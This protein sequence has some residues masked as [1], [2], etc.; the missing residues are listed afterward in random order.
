MG[1]KASA[2]LRVVACVVGCDWLSSLE[3]GG[4]KHLRRHWLRSLRRRPKLIAY[5]SLYDLSVE[6][7]FPDLWHCP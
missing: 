6:L 5:S 1:G 4:R 7:V 2:A 3:A